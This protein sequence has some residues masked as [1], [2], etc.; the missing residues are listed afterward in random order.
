MAEEHNLEPENTDPDPASDAAHFAGAGAS[1]V[2]A[3]QKA[4]TPGQRLAARKA[5]KSAKKKEFK[6]E[7]K[8]NEL[9]A[10][11]KAQAGSRILASEPALPE[12]VQQVARDFSDFA[13]ENQ[14]RILGGIAAFVVISA[15]VILAQRF[16]T[17][18]NAEAASALESAIETAQ[19]AI[20]AEDKD[21]KTDDGKRVF[22]TSE[23]RAKKTAEAFGAVSKKF[24]DEAVSAWAQLGEA[25]ARMA[26]G[27]NAQAMTLYESVYAEG[28][29]DPALAARALEGLGLALE[30]LGKPD[31]AR[32]RFNELKAVAGARNKD[33]AEYHLARLDL[34]KG[35]RESAKTLL[36][37]LYDRLSER[38]E[39][40]PESKYL[41]GEVE[42][43]LAEIDSSLVDKGVSPIGGGESFS[44]E[45]LQQLLQQMRSKG[46]APPEGAGAE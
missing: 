33:T 8:Q 9:D 36:K 1:A 30:A 16:M 5:S 31:Q 26:L 11:E 46:G 22:A 42:I 44:P 3:L 35:D 23:A 28:K 2:P 25:S 21:G 4:M 38:G 34:A 43:R 6:A 20:D 17:T 13:H 32:K 45:Q 40:E 7:L 19:A 18:G 29:G 37:G 41:K 24:R 14:G 12:E 15:V 39:G 10:Q 27:A